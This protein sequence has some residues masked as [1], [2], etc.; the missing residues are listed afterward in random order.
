MAHYKT[1]QLVGGLLKI[2]ELGVVVGVG[3]IAPNTVQLIDKYLDKKSSSDKEYKRLINHM[4]RLGLISID[5]LSNENTYVSLTDKGKQ[6]LRDVYMED[7]MIAEPK[8]WD[9]LWR[10]V[11]FDIPRDKRNERYEF[12]EQLRRLGFVRSLQSMWVF[13]Y[14][15]TEQ[16]YA[17]AT[18]I[19][20]EKNMMIF[21]AKT[22]EDIH[23]K[24]IRNFKR[25][26]IRHI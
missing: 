14:P 3:S 17:I 5:S 6:R 24:L 16:I 11:S 26:L 20:I 4:K 10:V 1:R 2:F 7:V 21:E 18:L 13:P 8:T 19:G 15:C 23:K 12:L 22:T 25:T 9:G